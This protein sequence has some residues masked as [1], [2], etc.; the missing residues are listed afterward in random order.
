MTKGRDWDKKASSEPR[1]DVS[2]FTFRKFRVI[3]GS[4][5]SAVRRFR[6]KAADPRFAVHYR[7]LAEKLLK[8]PNRG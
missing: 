5:S 3:E 4:G 1:P 8:I 7:N 2:A 6:L